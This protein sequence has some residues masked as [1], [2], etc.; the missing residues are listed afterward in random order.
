M[1]SPSGLCQVQ[2][3]ILGYSIVAPLTPPDEEAS[4][5]QLGNPLQFFGNTDV[6]D[7]Q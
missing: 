7:G 3:V 6:P 2:V 4:C 1:T 5:V